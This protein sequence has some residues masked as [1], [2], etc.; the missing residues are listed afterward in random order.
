[1]LFESTVSPLVYTLF[2]ALGVGVGLPMGPAVI[3]AGALYGGLNGFWTGR[4]WL[5]RESR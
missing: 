2:L 5:S 3:G 1:M 4:T